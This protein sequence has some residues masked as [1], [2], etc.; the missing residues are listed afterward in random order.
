MGLKC[1]EN[2][3]FVATQTPARCLRSR[4]NP[5]VPSGMPLTKLNDVM[6]LFI[7]TS[8]KLSCLLLVLLTATVEHHSSANSK[9]P[10]VL[11]LFN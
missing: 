10:N 9:T 11:M 5:L 3:P 7:S 2:N 1:K 4:N 6:T 8:L